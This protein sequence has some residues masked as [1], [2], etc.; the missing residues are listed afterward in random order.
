M[1]FDCSGIKAYSGYYK[2]TGKLLQSA[3]G[4]GASILSEIILANGGAVFGA[5]YSPDFMTAEYSFVDRPEELHR[6][7]G[8]KYIPTLKRVMINGEY[9]P[10]WPLVAQKLNEGREILFTGLGCDVA[11]LHSYLKANHADSSRLFTVDLICYGPTLPEVHRQYVLSLEAKFHS[12]LKSF[13]VRHKAT[14]WTPPYIRAEFQNGK[15]FLIP[16]YGSD[17][18]QV[19]GKYPREQCSKCRFKGTYHQADITLGDYWGITPEMQ[20]WNHTGVSIFLVRTPRGEELLNRIDLKEFALR[21][22]DT[23]FVV[24]NNP[25]YYTSRKMPENYSKFCDELVSLGLHRA[26]INLNG[27]RLKHFIRCVKKLIPSPLRRM[28]RNLRDI[29]VPNKSH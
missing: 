10:L 7:K 22:E 23:S 16:F 2:D 8:S 27:G 14:G 26:V 19:F 20:G 29:I 12:H 17:Y 24:E 1:S 15:E 13:T 25:M 18:G 3:S 9:V 21:P 4:G 5:C 6:L 28:L 11:A